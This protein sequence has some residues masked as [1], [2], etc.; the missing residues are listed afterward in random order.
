MAAGVTKRLWEIGDVVDV[1]EAWEAKP[2]V[3][4][5]FATIKVA[6]DRQPSVCS[7]NG[8]PS[9]RGV[10]G[11]QA[12]SGPVR[13]GDRGMD[14]ASSLLAP[15]HRRLNRRLRWRSAGSAFLAAPKDFFT[16]CRINEASFVALSCVGRHR[17][18]MI[19]SPCLNSEEQRQCE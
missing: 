3:S 18:G 11:L 15:C 10:I 7:G 17:A 2:R 9:S 14:A 6:H 5:G 16:A 4:L 8:A 19:L 13:F 12:T 1:L